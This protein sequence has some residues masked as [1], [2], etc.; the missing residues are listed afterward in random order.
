MKWNLLKI[1]GHG[2]TCTIQL[3]DFVQITFLGIIYACR[4]I[5]VKQVF[6]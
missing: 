5:L 4:L 6:E 1:D 3:V 2:N